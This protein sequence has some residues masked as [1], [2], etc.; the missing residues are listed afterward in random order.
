MESNKIKV[1]VFPKDNNPYQELLYKPLNKKVSISFID[2]KESISNILTIVPMTLYSLAKLR[3]KGYKILHIHWLYLFYLPNKIPLNKFFSFFYTYIFLFCISKM[4]FKIVWTVH[5]VIPQNT[6]TIN[7]KL[8]MK[9]LSSVAEVKI[10][11]SKAVLEDMM[12][13]N[14][15]TN[16]TH[17]IPIGSYDNIYPNITNRKDARRKLQIKE[18]EFT[19][20]HFGIISPYKGAVDLIDC[21]LKLNLKNSRLIIAGR[22]NNKDLKKQI[23]TASNHKKID[24]YEGFVPDDQVSLYFNA[25]DI[26][27]LPFRQI[28]T[29]S[30]VMLALAFKK[31]IIVP[32]LGALKDLPSSV[33][34]FYNPKQE[35]GLE[36]SIA[37]AHSDLITLAKKSKNAKDYDKSLSWDKIATKTFAIYS[38]LL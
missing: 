25:A 22:C 16:N 2:P 5:N 10:I 13:K 24:F 21:F 38:D 14:L 37:K 17:V 34:Y 32:R 33:G 4:R 15:S 29:S 8:L 23:Q 18:K 9:R 31:A 19:I 12:S 26:V 7:D 20:L 3:I 27:C 35:N 1:I 36:N 28:T 6:A 30:S 11:H